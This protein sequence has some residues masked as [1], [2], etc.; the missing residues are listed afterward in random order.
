MNAN[1]PRCQQ[2]NFTHSRTTT[3]GKRI[4]LIHCVACGCVVGAIENN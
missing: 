4:M 1:C 2:S 3:G